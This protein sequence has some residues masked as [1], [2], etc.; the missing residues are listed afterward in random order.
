MTD[1]ERDALAK[2]SA[3][4]TANTAMLLD[5]LANGL[6]EDLQQIWGALAAINARL[7]PPPDKP[8]PKNGAPD[9]G[10]RE[11]TGRHELLGGIVFEVPDSTKRA[12]SNTY[13]FAKTA[14][15]FVV[16]GIGW[17]LATLHWLHIL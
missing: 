3:R 9:A 5:Q 4:S 10:A 8:K 12:A 14:G 15:K 17:V 1:D 2:S 13:E 7:P 11:H 16:G 6:C